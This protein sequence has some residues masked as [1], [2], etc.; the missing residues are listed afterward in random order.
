[1]SQWKNVGSLEGCLA[2][3]TL[4]PGSRVLMHWPTEA[5][6]NPKAPIPT[7]EGVLVRDPISHTWFVE[8]ENGIRVKAP[9]SG[10]LRLEGA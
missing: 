6:P 1:M 8:F 10:L 2:R 7:R 3:G 5:L 4:K 9:A